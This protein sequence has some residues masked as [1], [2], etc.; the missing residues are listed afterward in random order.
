MRG[1]ISTVRDFLNETP[2]AVV[3]QLL[4]TYP[5]ASASQI[6][7]WE[8][9][10]N[11]IKSSSSFCK[12]CPSAVISLELSLF[13]ENMS[14]DLLISG[15][16]FSNDNIAFLIESK[17]WGDEYMHEHRL[18][19]YRET[20]ALLHPQVQVYHHYLS[21]RDYIHVVPSITQ[22][23]PFVYMR[24][25]SNEGCTY[26]KETNPDVITVDIPIFN[27]IDDIFDIIADNL[28]NET[29]ISA[30]TLRE[31]TYSPSLSIIDSM[32][33]IV[34]REVPFILTDEQEQVLLHILD[35]ISS[36][37]RI[38]QINGSAGSGKTAI[39][40]NI[41]VRMLRKNN[42]FMPL[43]VSGAQNTHLY[44]SLYPEVAGSFNFTFS[45]RNTIRNLQNRYPVILLD[46]AQHNQVGII[47]D[48]LMNP[49]TIVI[50]CYDEWQTINANN[51]LS[52]ILSFK[53]REDFASISLNN[54]VRF[55]GSQIFESNVKAYLTS[56]RV[57]LHDDLYDFRVFSSF[58]EIKDETYKIINN[59]PESEVALLGLLSSDAHDLSLASNGFMHVSWENKA[60]TRWIPYIKEKNYLS[61]NNGSLWV[62]TWWMPGLDIDYSVL[63]IGDDARLTSNGFEGIPRHSKNYLMMISIAEQ[64]GLPERI[65]R[66]NVSN[67]KKVENILNYL[68]LSGNEEIKQL[69]NENFS[70]YL[71]NMYYVMMTR[72]RKGCFVYFK[73]QE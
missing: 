72:G 59:N 19:A 36:G 22:I 5:E 12:I 31:A 62:G 61:K 57:P 37:K 23:Y 13:V 26:L 17:Q 6:R 65:L 46:E 32:N 16:A 24:N 35:L 33:A 11:D 14:V 50:L 52:E 40:L 47:S 41:Y 69:F 54:N 27:N 29:L 18:S 64:L 49:S 20:D 1:Y 34:T 71:R 68:D 38:I 7:S 73:N 9:L 58:D 66:G 2:Q 53:E 21:F 63:I 30:D 48:L 10:I 42:R 55:N 39:L 56:A 15:T 8:V 51:A 60:E 43:F 44:K 70:L 67:S 3:Q 4:N 25:A 28:A 45:L